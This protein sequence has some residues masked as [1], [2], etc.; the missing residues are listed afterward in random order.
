MN[1]V[2]K[3]ISY[4]LAC[5]LATFIIV[6]TSIIR[7][8]TTSEG[9]PILLDIWLFMVILELPLAVIVM[10]TLNNLLK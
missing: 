1:R 8:T 6:I 4:L 7:H 9:T 3:F 10:I 2:V 5:N